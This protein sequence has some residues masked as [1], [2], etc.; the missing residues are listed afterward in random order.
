MARAFESNEGTKTSQDAM[1][2]GEWTGDQTKTS[3]EN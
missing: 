1:L 3:F 2:I